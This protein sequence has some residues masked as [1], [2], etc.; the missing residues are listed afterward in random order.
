MPYK[1]PQRQRAHNQVYSQ[2][3][4]ARSEI[5]ARRNEQ[6]KLR[7]LQPGHKAKEQDWQLRRRYGITLAK[8]TSLLRAQGNRCAICD[9][10]PSKSSDWH[11]DHDHATGA[12]RGILCR[13]CNRALGAVRDNVET[14]RRAIAYLTGGQ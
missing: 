5:K 6:Q 13:H 7:R 10:A 12:V 8:Y 4:Q 9:D 3:W 1:D 2:K 11:V 14:L